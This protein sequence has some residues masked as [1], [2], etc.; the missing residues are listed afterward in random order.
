M[1]FDTIGVPWMYEPQGFLLAD[2]LW[3]LPDFYL[4][5]LE[6]Y[7]EIKAT[8]PSELEARKAR[9]LAEA[10]Q[11][12]V[13]LFGQP[14]YMCDSGYPSGQIADDSAHLW[15]G[16]SSHLT[17]GQAS[18]DNGYTWC[19]SPCGVFGIEYHGRS[20]RIAC[21]REGHGD[22]KAYS[23]DDPRLL[24]AY[25]AANRARFDGARR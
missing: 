10:T 19:V 12:R 6:C 21:C 1:F 11:S 23:Y 2:D 25:D 8:P 4:P 5:H 24:R 7:V 13:F 9:L 17:D 14:G 20:E 22:A 15:D 16:Q 18:W 3:Y